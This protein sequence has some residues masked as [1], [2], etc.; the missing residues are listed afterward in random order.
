MNENIHCIPA[1]GP[2]NIFYWLG[3][4]AARDQLS[5]E[6]LSMRLDRKVSHRL[7]N[8]TLHLTDADIDAL[9]EAFDVIRDI[10]LPH[11]EAFGIDM[12]SAVIPVVREIHNVQ[13][14]EIWQYRAEVGDSKG[15]ALATLHRRKAAA[16]TIGMDDFWKCCP[17]RYIREQSPTP[18]HGD[19]RHE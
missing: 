8:G 4:Q 1:V 11:E 16:E 12:L 7:R 17:W 6:E 3:I 2:S 10:K 13:M 5:Y 9:H 18:N 19:R 14:A 15:L